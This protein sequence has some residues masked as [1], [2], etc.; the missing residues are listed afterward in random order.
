MELFF[1]QNRMFQKEDKRGQDR[2][3]KLLNSTYTLNRSLQHKNNTER[4]IIHERN[5]GTLQ[6]QVAL[7]NI[8]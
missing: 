5:Q 3:V 4:I 7:I 2:V 6:V 8:L 1:Y